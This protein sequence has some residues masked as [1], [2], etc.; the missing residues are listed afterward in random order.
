M[1]FITPGEPAAVPS[2]AP[3]GDG[4]AVLVL[5]ALGQ[6]DSYTSGVRNVLSELGYQAFGWDLGPNIGPTPRLRQGALD[7]LTALSDAHGPVSLVGYSMGGLFARWLAQQRPDRVRR[8]IS[9][10][11]PIHEAGKNFWMPIE[12]VIG[13]LAG[14]DLTALKQEIAGPVPVE[15]TVLFSSA[16]GL[17]NWTSC[18]DD[19]V[20]PEEN[21]DIGGPHVLIA[22]NPNMMRIVADRLARPVPGRSKAV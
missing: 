17:V 14:E 22:R 2:G 16:D 20:P 19:A 13:L 6:T 5:P 3:R 12:P 4:H 8:F 1:A 15:G 7:R 10:C 11:S 18:H 21:I 9:V